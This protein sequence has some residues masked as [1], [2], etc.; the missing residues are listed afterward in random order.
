MITSCFALCMLA[1]AVPETDF[2][3]INY[4]LQHIDR[5]V[6]D[7]QW[8]EAL[9][10]FERLH[11]AA[12][13]QAIARIQ[14][15]W[16]DNPG[17]SVLKEVVNGYLPVFQFGLSL[18]LSRHASEPD[19]RL[20]QRVAEQSYRWVI[21]GKV[22]PRQIEGDLLAGRPVGTLPASGPAL[23][24]RVRLGLQARA[25]PAGGPTRAAPATLVEIVRFT[26]SPISVGDGEGPWY[27]AWVLT[28]VADDPVRLVDFGP[29]TNSQQD[30]IDDAVCKWQSE[31]RAAI[32]HIENQGDSN[33][34][35]TTPDDQ[36]TIARCDEILQ[37]LGKK[38]LGR[39]KLGTPEVSPEASPEATPFLF[40]SPAADLWLVPFSAIP[41]NTGTASGPAS[42]TSAAAMSRRHVIDGFH[43][44]YLISSRELLTFSPPTNAGQLSAFLT[45]YPDYDIDGARS[46]ATQDERRLGTSSAS[47]RTPNKTGT[48]SR[49]PVDVRGTGIPAR[50]PGPVS[51][52]PS[53][54]SDNRPSPAGDR[55]TTDVQYAW[56]AERG[57]FRGTPRPAERHVYDFSVSDGYFLVPSQPSCLPSPPSCWVV[58]APTPVPEL[59]PEPKPQRQSPLTMSC[60]P[61]DFVPLD[62]MKELLSVTREALEL[63]KVQ[64]SNLI[65]KT[66]LDASER[67]VR[68]YLGKLANADAPQ[69]AFRIVMF[70]SHGC[71][72]N[73]GSDHCGRSDG[74]SADSSGT[75]DIVGPVDPLL[76]C[77]IAMAG[78]NG[79]EKDSPSRVD[80]EDGLLTGR[81]VAADLRL[82][83]TD[84]VI[85][86]ACQT[87]EGDIVGGNLAAMR[88]AFSI[89]G[90][91]SVVASS[92]T[93]AAA[94]TKVLIDQFV[95]DYIQTRDAAKSLR[96][97]QLKMKHKI[98]YRHP[99]YWA[100]F[101]ITGEAR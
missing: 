79:A 67:V 80:G 20:R 18:A 63:A 17:A 37:V 31:L 48:G 44:I 74:T 94:P 65:V 100:P 13:E 98:Q 73:H 6:Q 59:L 91:R 1:C 42:D 99:V 62:S 53:S 15:H 58:P 52:G 8:D 22:L 93:V 33:Y 81:E 84:I 78:A 83:D 51:L 41:T 40:L 88:H 35:L 69:P 87:G 7:R 66:E 55:W 64:E 95:N 29:A 97:T 19:E 57:R 43:V 28:D 34:L 68:E 21:A 75:E 47:G 90:A 86:A 46:V 92:W 101:S 61:G 77:Y 36:G 2:K 10:R 4:E 25:N 76:G 50:E 39:L 54:N 56:V 89:V 70:A 60:K 85:L 45:G 96:D 30:G 27:A 38:T 26:R 12:R 9:G 14:T 3:P 16:P 49:K 71:Y 72:A 24:E 32:R 82:P 11:D 5:L 23:V